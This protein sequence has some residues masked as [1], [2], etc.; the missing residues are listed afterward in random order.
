MIQGCTNVYGDYL[1]ARVPVY[2]CAARAKE[3]ERKREREGKR[4]KERDPSRARLTALYV[5]KG[6]I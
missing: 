2:R 4:E 3:K 5:L 6:N 1:E